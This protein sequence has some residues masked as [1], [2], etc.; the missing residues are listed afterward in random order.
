MMVL[1]DKMMGQLQLMRDDV[2]SRHGTPSRSPPRLPQPYNEPPPAHYE[3]PDKQW[4]VH[5]PQHDDDRAYGP[6]DR[7]QSSYEP[8]VRS[9]IDMYQNSMPL[10]AQKPKTSFLEQPSIQIKESAAEYRGPKPSIP[11]LVYKDPSRFARLKLALHNLL[12][13]DVSELFKFQILVDYLQLEEAKLIA[14]SFLNSPYPYTATMAALTENFVKP[15]QLALSKIAQVMDAQDV[16]PG[17]PE[18]FKRSICSLHRSEVDAPELGEAQGELNRIAESDG[19][20]EPAKRTAKLYPGPQITQLHQRDHR[21]TR[22]GAVMGNAGTPLERLAAGA[23]C[24]C[25]ECV[26]HL[27]AF[28]QMVRE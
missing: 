12:P 20:E 8:A 11:Y 22:A 13:E 2:A 25:V 7:F 9:K 18:A 19:P 21:H 26:R 24:L 17:D 4:Y 3:Y 23:E 10:P 14:D 1:I 16:C 28:R 27:P 15:H 5:A 6:S